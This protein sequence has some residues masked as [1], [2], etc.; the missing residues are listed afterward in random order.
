MR[1]MLIPPL[2]ENELAMIAVRSPLRISFGGGGT[3]LPAYCER[4]GGM[5]VSAAIIP[6]CH[7]SLAP[8]APAR[9]HRRIPRLW[10]GCCR[11]AV[12]ATRS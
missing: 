5:V 2:S 6:A 8:T 7:V 12:S 3:D 4:F 1:E 9:G 10:A 11:G